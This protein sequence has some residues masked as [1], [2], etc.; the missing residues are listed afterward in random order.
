MRITWLICDEYYLSY[1]FFLFSKDFEYQNSNKTN[2]GPSDADTHDHA[3]SH[4]NG[5]N[6]HHHHHQQHQPS[7]HNSTFDQ[8]KALVEGLQEEVHSLK[9]LVRKQE[10]RILKLENERFDTMKLDVPNYWRPDSIEA[11]YFFF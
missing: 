10:R 6:K 7:E 11:F 4:T 8:M 9:D 3:P 5:N 1:L 2:N